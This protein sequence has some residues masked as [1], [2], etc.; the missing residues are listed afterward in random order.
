MKVIKR[1]GTVEPFDIRKIADALYRVYRDTG[2]RTKTKKI[3]KEQAKEIAAKY[4]EN[5]VDIDIESIQDDVEN[6]LMAKREFAVARA[7]IK[8]REKQ[9]IDRENP[10]ADND[11]RQDL[12]LGKYLIKGETK[13]D[14][15]KRI[16][17]G[18]SKLEKIFRHR[19]G[20]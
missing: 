11:E 18:N 10:W 12:I 4:F 1:N 2:S 17:F 19:E 6:Y 7:Y 9:K 20:I 8:Y 5:N 3:C 14:F 13:Q 15:L 16:S